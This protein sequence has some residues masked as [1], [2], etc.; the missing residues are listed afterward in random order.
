MIRRPPRSTLFPYTTL[1]RSLETCELWNSG[2]QRYRLPFRAATNEELGLVHS[3]DYIAA[4]QSLSASGP[5]NEDERKQHLQDRKST[6]LNSSHGYISYAV[7]CLKKTHHD[8]LR[9]S[10]PTGEVRSELL[11]I[12]AVAEPVDRRPIS[13]ARD[14]QWLRSCRI[15]YPH[16]CILDIVF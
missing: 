1:F 2:D 8:G 11:E 7:F 16:D 15:R 5:E 4:V 3:A 6:R 13:P 14:L 12:P 10:R 9:R